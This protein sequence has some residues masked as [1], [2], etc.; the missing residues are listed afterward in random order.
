VAK[1]LTV[2]NGGSTTM[3]GTVNGA[4]INSGGSLTV[5]NGAAATG[6]IVDNGTF[7]FDISGK[8]TF[9]GDLTGNGSMIVQGG[10]KLVVTSALQSNVAIL[11]GAYSSLELGAASNSHITLGY[12]NRLVLDHSL[13]FTGTIAASPGNRDSIDLVD[14]AFIQGK[15][16]DHFVENAAHTQGVLTVQDQGGSSVQLTM[17]GDFTPTA[18][19]INSDGLATPGTLISF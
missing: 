8:S 7:A 11:L 17:L 18:F 6:S 16:M 2:N 19:R 3:L 14:L 10:G 12:Q 13:D 5:Y 1:N 15:T 4:T 9:G